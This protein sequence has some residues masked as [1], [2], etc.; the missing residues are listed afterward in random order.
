MTV[1]IN[2]V[3]VPRPVPD[4]L[5][6]FLFC[7]V[8]DPVGYGISGKTVSAISS[9]SLAHHRRISALKLTQLLRV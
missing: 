7:S 5:S 2:R 6:P 4:V 8:T 9:P 1:I 3:H